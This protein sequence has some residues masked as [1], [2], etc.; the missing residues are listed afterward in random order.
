MCEEEKYELVVK[1]KKRCNTCFGYA[2]DPDNCYA[3]KGEG[4]LYED[5]S[6]KEALELLGVIAQD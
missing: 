2:N 3:C 6:L 4:W 5:I 1:K